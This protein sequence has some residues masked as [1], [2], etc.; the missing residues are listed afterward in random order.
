MLDTG[1]L[2]LDFDT[3]GE[4]SELLLPMLAVAVL[5]QKQAALIPCSV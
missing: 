3:G 4:A 1:Q 2:V 5:A